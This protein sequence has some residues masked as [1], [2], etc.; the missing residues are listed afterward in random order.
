MKWSL[1]EQVAT[2]PKTNILPLMISLR[3]NNK[4]LMRIRWMR[5]GDA[6]VKSQM[7]LL[8]AS[9]HTYWLPPPQPHTKEHYWAKLCHRK[10]GVLRAQMLGM[11]PRE[12]VWTLVTQLF[13]I[14]H[15]P[16]NGRLIISQWW[17]PESSF[18]CCVHQLESNL[19]ARTLMCTLLTGGH[20][21]TQAQ[22][23]TAV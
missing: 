18:I 1:I 20:A 21:G 3:C 13:K 2:E 15:H 5:F 12:K 8:T 9:V 7:E 23:G 6:T 16:S 4:L 10:L 22:V 17:T 11:T 14:T 19:R